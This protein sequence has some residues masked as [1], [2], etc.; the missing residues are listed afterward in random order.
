MR[1]LSNGYTVEL[2]QGRHLIDGTPG[3]TF[4]DHDEKSI[5]ITDSYGSRQELV[6]RALE[7]AD[8][9]FTAAPAVAACRES[10]IEILHALCFRKAPL[11]PD[12]SERL[13][14]SRSAGA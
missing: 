4:I 14:F 10:T 3:R 5:V 12:D 6:D 2:V 11:I 13:P 7:A 8:I 9:S 1:T